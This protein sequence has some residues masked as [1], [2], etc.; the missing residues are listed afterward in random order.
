MP[1]PSTP[2]SPITPHPTSTSFSSAHTPSQRSSIKLN[3]PSRC[4]IKQLPSGS[5]AKDVDQLIS[6]SKTVK[7]ELTASDATWCVYT[8]MSL[9]AETIDT[10]GTDQM[11]LN[12]LMASSMLLNAIVSA[13]EK[14]PSCTTYL[15][16][17]MSKSVIDGIDPESYRCGFSAFRALT[18]SVNEYIDSHSVDITT[19]KLQ[20]MT[21][22]NAPWGSWSLV[23]FD[24]REHA[25]ETLRVKY[26]RQ[27]RGEFDHHERSTLLA[28]SCT[29]APGPKIMKGIVTGPPVARS[30]RKPP[31]RKSPATPTP[32]ATVDP[33][34]IPGGVYHEYTLT[35]SPVKAKQSKIPT[36]A[37]INEAAEHESSDSEPSV[38]TTSDIDEKIRLIEIAR[39]QFQD[40]VDSSQANSAHGTPR[41]NMSTIFFVPDVEK[42]YFYIDIHTGR[43][44]YLHV[45]QQ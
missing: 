28:A 26:T 17:V 32:T 10:Q 16:D 42:N 18:Q 12:K 41:R 45:G 14:N 38:P 4:T 35:V 39:S 37:P 23:E 11:S 36:P 22:F 27:L 15:T 30:D 3:T 40:R 44:A 7:T 21:L 2:F 24:E 13:L 8:A 1:S 5:G 29:D 20:L 43:P 9:T 25:V 31:A 34:D 19:A 6:W 33:K